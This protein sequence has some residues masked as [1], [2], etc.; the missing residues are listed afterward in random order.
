MSGSILTRV[1]LIF[2]NLLTVG[3]ARRNDA[4]GRTAHGVDH[5]EH[6]TL[7]RPE[8]PIA[9]LAVVPTAVPADD[10]VVIQ[11]GADGV[12]EIEA[13]LRETGIVLGIVPFEFRGMM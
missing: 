7:Y 1:L 13:A 6:A 2:P 10:P 9:V 4:D 5:D 3:F 8:Q 11:K 12:G